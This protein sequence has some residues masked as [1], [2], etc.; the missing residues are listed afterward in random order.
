M[1]PDVNTNRKTD[2]ESFRRWKKAKSSDNV[3]VTKQNPFSVGDK[4]YLRTDGKCT[5]EWSGPHR[6]TA[7]RSVVAVELDDDGISR[8]IVHLK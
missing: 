7:I 3:D 1:K 6:V 2:C 8:H 5:S 4:V